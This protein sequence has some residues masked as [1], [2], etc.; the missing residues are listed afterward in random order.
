M[1]GEKVEIKIQYGVDSQIVEGKIINYLGNDQYVVE[2]GEHKNRYIRQLEKINGVIKVKGI[3]RV[4]SEL[5]DFTD[6]QLSEVIEYAQKQLSM[7]H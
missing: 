1:I 2:V 4:K 6:L 7:L 5:M 3:D